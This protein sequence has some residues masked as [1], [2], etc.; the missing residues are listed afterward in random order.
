MGI[1]SQPPFPLRRGSYIAPEHSPVRR[2]Q[3]TPTL[4]G[5][6]TR[7]VK[8]QVKITLL[9]LIHF[10]IYISLKYNKV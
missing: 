5:A 9:C 10:Y 3:S 6:S 2:K 1:N 4:R 7:L 8:V